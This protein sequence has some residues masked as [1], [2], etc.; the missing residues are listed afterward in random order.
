MIVQ[1]NLYLPGQDLT[2]LAQN[3]DF[4]RFQDFKGNITVNFGT[5]PATVTVKVGTILEVNG[6]LYAIETADYVF[7][8]DNATHNYLTFTDNPAVDFGSA[9]AIGTYTAAKQGY[10][11]AGNLIR[12]L[13]FYIDQ[14]NSEV[15]R[16]MDEQYNF[17]RPRMKSFDRVFV[18]LSGDINLGG[19]AANA[20]FPFNTEIYDELGNWNIGTYK[21]TTSETGWYLINIKAYSYIGDIDSHN[22][23]L[24]NILVNG[25]IESIFVFGNVDSIGGEVHQGYGSGN[26]LLLKYLRVGDTVH[27]TYNKA[28]AGTLTIT[29]THATQATILRI[30]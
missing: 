7:S 20:T 16:L 29:A 4:N 19:G 25:A 3:V 15:S 30:I 11:Q 5:V 21:F 10:Y 12:T 18:T 24:G 14:A 22:Y 27:F 8:M 26:A 13:P 28:G 1:K 9:A 17:N 23:I 6:N 2:N